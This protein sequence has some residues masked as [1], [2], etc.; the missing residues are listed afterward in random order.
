MATLQRNIGERAIRHAVVESAI[1]Q[2]DVEANN[3]RR[4]LFWL[5]VEQQLEDGHQQIPELG[6]GGMYFV[7]DKDT[8]EF[9]QVDGD[10]L[11]ARMDTWAVEKGWYLREI[12][13]AKCK[14]GKRWKRT[15]TKGIQGFVVTAPPWYSN[16]IFEAARSGESAR[17]QE[18]S[19]QAAFELR[20]VIEK[21]TGRQVLS[22]QAHFDTVNLHWHV[23]S[24]RIG[25]DHKFRRGT[26]KRIGLVGPWAVAT[27]RQ[28]EVGAI[29]VE[30]TNYKTARWLC[31]RNR[32]RTG[33]PPL[34]WVMART[35]DSLCFALFGASP[36][37]GFWL[38]LYNQGLPALCYNR[39]LALNDAVGRELR[40]WERHAATG[41]DY[42]PAEVGFGRG[43]NGG[44]EVTFN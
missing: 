3:R 10:Q 36:R 11:I 20:D 44:K 37:L 7:L 1:H 40:A 8:G 41:R 4:N 22:V 12:K 9:L 33:S 28:G 23:F 15:P 26:S 14:T 27:L 43:V 5:G 25:D 39:L 38:R 2:A 16:V 42:V 35:V 17:V 21:Q 34:D 18:L 6:G 29:P 19:R 30:S 24:S 32:R 31:E 13:D